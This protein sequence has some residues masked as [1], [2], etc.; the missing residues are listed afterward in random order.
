MRTEDKLLKQIQNKIKRDTVG[1]FSIYFNYES[2][3]EVAH[4]E[5]INNT[6]CKTLDC[7]MGEQINL[8]TVRTMH[9][10]FFKTT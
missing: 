1:N 2:P 7:F 10:Q 8:E 4:I 9:P 5:I 3:D 6:T